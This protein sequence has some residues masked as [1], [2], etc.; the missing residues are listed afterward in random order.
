[1]DSGDT[2]DL[3][4]RD[5]SKAF[6]FVNHRFVI[7]KLKAY[8]INDKVV[9][10]IESFLKERTFNV[11]INGNISPSKAAGSGVPQGSML[12]RYNGCFPPERTK[13]TAQHPELMFSRHSFRWNL[14]EF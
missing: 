6:N 5:F 8:V 14:R 2:M 11:S 7:K 10:W 4:F 9:N 1:M 12:G 3:V 13:T